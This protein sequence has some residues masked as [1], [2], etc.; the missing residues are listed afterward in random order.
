MMD[1]YQFSQPEVRQLERPSR[2]SFYR[3]VLGVIAISKIGCLWLNLNA[4][5]IRQA[6]RFTDFAGG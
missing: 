1:Q 3:H 5:L 6:I 2:D 4:N